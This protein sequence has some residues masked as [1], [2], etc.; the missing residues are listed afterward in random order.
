ML[1]D[2]ENIAQADWLTQRKA[3]AHQRQG[4]YCSI[5]SLVATLSVAAE[6]ITGGRG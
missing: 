6:K 4:W 1:D 3:C 2:A 5:F